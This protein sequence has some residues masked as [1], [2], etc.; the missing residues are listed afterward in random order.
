MLVGADVERLTSFQ[1]FF[2]QEILRGIR[3]WDRGITFVFAARI[4]VCSDK[5]CLSLVAQAIEQ[6]TLVIVTGGL[7]RNAAIRQLGATLGDSF[8]AAR[9]RAKVQ[10]GGACI[11][12]RRS[13]E[14]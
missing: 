6:K 13:V 7:R 12:C 10:Q 4:K 2:P 8:S 3:S 11:I 14:R 1:V 5:P 9:R